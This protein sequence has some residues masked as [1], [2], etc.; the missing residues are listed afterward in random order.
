MYTLPVL[1]LTL[2]LAHS[3]VDT[4]LT[5]VYCPN[6]LPHLIQLFTSISYLPLLYDSNVN[7]KYKWLQKLLVTSLQL[8]VHSSFQVSYHNIICLLY[9]KKLLVPRW[10]EGYKLFDHHENHSP[11]TILFC[12]FL[13]GTE[14]VAS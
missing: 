1:S 4:C 9:T 2:K 5:I 8:L 6:C 14:K 12:V 10:L 13:F 7:V 3:L 11:S